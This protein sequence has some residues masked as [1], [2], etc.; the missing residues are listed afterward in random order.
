MKTMKQEIHVVLNR[1]YTELCVWIQ[2]LQEKGIVQER[3]WK[4]LQQEV[5]RQKKN[6]FISKKQLEDFRRQLSLLRYVWGEPERLLEA[7]ETLLG[8][9][10]L[11]GKGAKLEPFQYVKKGVPFTEEELQSL[12]TILLEH[13][14]ALFEPI[15]LELSTK[16][17]QKNFSMET[18]LEKYAHNEESGYAEWVDKNGY[19]VNIEHELK[20]NMQN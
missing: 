16:L 13:V 11:L 5:K 4:D 19:S 1:W 6:E 15:E 10:Y 9:L 20:P 8:F 17:N 7:L 3:Y 18:L 14:P 12:C 2:V